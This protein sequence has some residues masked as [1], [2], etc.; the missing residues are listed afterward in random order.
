MM[1][2][3]IYAR[4]LPRGFSASLY[5]TLTP[6][7]DDESYM[8]GL[9]ISLEGGKKK[10]QMPGRKLPRVQD[11]TSLYTMPALSVQSAAGRNSPFS[12]WPKQEA[13]LVPRVVTVR[14][15]PTRHVQEV[16]GKSVY[17]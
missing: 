17:M 4:R 11:S 1:T 13:K 10:V 6:T 3:C 12:I 2:G 5:N 16:E 14:E 9:A 8:E 15:Y 7:H